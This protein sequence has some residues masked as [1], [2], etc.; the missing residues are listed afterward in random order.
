MEVKEQVDGPFTCGRSVGR[1][2]TSFRGKIEKCLPKV[3]FCV[4][5]WH[6]GSA[7]ARR[8]AQ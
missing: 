2:I 7:M 6:D 3:N 8:G 1:P 5:A 4:A